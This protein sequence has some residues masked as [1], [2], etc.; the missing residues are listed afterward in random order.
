GCYQPFQGGWV[1]RSTSGSF[2]V[3]TA[4]LSL[5]SSW[6]REYGDLGFPT[7]A[8]SADPATGN[9]TQAFQGGVVT[10]AGGIARFP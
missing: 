1:V 6:G 5:W 8:P 3:P 10:V 9:Y 4:V 7:G 2:A